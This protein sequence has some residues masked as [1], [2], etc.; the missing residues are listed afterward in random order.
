M[1]W[2][3][4]LT[5]TYT[6]YIFVTLKQMRQ[7]SAH[8]QY[9]LFYDAAVIA[10]HA[11]APE[12]GFRQRDFSFCLD[13]MLNWSCIPEAQGL[14]FHNTQALR[15]LTSL[16]TEGFAKRTRTVKNPHYRLTRLGLLELVNR[17]TSRIDIY[18]PHEFYFLFYFVSSYRERIKLLIEREGRQFPSSLRLE[19]LGLLDAEDLLRDELRRTDKAIENLDHQIRDGREGFRLY[20]EQ[21]KLG[22]S[23]DEAAQAV[24]IRYPYQLNSQ[25][26][27][28]K[29]IREIPK[30]IAEIELSTNSNRRVEQLFQPA[31]QL[32]LRHREN[33]RQLSR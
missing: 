18:T 4:G 22:K 17:M 3:G 13:L 26:P 30:D 10:A 31:R 8:N 14:R 15:F 9:L 7:H 16:S 33:L 20:T 32:L 5:A 11:N 25:K 24:E 21:R 2:F 12:E 19:I 29:L 28:T 23:I 6:Y 1:V 27:L